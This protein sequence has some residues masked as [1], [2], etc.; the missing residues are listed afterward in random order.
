MTDGEAE[1]AEIKDRERNFYFRADIGKAN[2]T[3]PA[4]DADWYKLVSV[5]LENGPDEGWTIN[6]GDQ[7]GVV[8]PWAY[9]VADMPRITPNDIVRIQGV[10][11]AGGPWRED[12]RA[13]SEQWV[14]IPIANGLGLDLLN[15]LDKKAVAAI[16]RDW[17]EAGLLKKVNGRDVNHEVRTY[18]E[19][20]SPPAVP[21]AVEQPRATGK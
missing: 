21:P 18:V 14:G 8:T 20:G 2:L 10:L 17:L 11:K 1:R 6:D 19:V 15:K 12:Q 7:V 9:P 16:V 4:E 5:N 3:P 13:K